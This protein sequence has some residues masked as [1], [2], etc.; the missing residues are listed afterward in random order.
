MQ[1]KKLNIEP[2]AVTG[3]VANL[4]NCNI[5]S[6]AGPVGFTMQQPYLLIKHIR[7]NNPTGAPVSLTC[8]KG[9]TAGSASGTQYAFPG[10]SIGANSYLDYF[11]EDRFDAADFLT[12]VGNGIV[13]TISAEIGVSG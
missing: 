11:S 5:T 13:L 4:L 8:Y 2:I 12:G 1:N 6:V 7:A 3:S 9:A 10:V